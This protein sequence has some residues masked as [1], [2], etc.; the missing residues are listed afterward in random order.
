MRLILIALVFFISC[1]DQRVPVDEQ[2]YGQHLLPIDSISE[3][4]YSDTSQTPGTG[5]YVWQVDYENKS[6]TKNS[7]HHQYF[8]VDSII[9][10]LNQLYPRIQLEKIKISGDTLFTEIKDS[11]YLGESIGSYGAN[12]YIANAV[13]NLTSV[14]N[15]YYV[16]FDFEDGS[17]IS[18]GT[19][20]KEQFRE[21]VVKQ[22]DHH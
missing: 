16:Q 21:Y 10:G 12:E 15:I 13:I 2:G 9:K 1:N 11:Y 3:K 18:S 19:W 4:H 17:H 7:Q 8:N 22:K 20:N 6:K 5:L 14:K